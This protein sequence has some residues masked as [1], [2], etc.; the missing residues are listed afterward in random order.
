MMS[1]IIYKFEP[2]KYYKK[3]LLSRPMLSMSAIL[4]HKNQNRKTMVDRKRKF[5]IRCSEFLR[6]LPYHAIPY[7]KIRIVR[8]C[9]DWFKKKK[10]ASE[11]FSDLYVLPFIVQKRSWETSNEE[12]KS[13]AF[14]PILILW[15]N[16]ADIFSIGKLKENFLAHLSDG[17]VSF[18]HHLASVVCRPLTFHILIFSSETPLPNELKLGR[19]HL[20]KVL[21]KDC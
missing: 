14:C 10:R 6:I 2:K 19:K 17:N 21:F 20:W 15:I 9:F 3:S 5:L 1:L 11:R 8:I 7:T 18:C 16:I 4:I 12:S 13:S